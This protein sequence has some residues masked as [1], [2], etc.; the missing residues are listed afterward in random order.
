MN[1]VLTFWQKWRV[2]I[3]G[4]A[5]SIVFTL[6]EMLSKP[7]EEQSV[8]VYILAGVMALLSFVASQW[9]GQGVT[10]TG[11]IGTLAYTFVTIQQTGNFTWG[12]FALA[13]LV[14]ILGAVAP[15][16]KPMTYE[17]NKQIVDA[18][19]MPPVDQVKDTTTLPKTP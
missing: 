8:K 16:P 2:F 5:S 3:I 10:I 7:Q 1:T 9:R 19:E 18:K 11:I 4:A 15:P 17:T 6:Q 13:A 14:A 12:Q